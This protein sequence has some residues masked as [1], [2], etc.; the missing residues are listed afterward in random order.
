MQARTGGKLG[1]EVGMSI[2]YGLFISEQGQVYWI[3]VM[4]YN[5]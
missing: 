3:V 5:F 1:L 2:V 4:S